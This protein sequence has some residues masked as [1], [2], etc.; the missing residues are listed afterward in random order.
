MPRINSPSFW[1]LLHGQMD[2][3]LSLSSSNK[4]NIDIT[5]EHNTTQQ[6]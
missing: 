1:A 4:S 3:N 2:G 6:C 5:P